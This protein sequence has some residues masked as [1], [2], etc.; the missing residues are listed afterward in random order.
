MNDRFKFRYFDKSEKFMYNVILFDVKGN[1][2]QVDYFHDKEIP[3][4]EVK[5]SDGILMQ[6]T[7]LKDKNVTLIYEGDILKCKENIIWVIQYGHRDENYF[8]QCA[9][10]S[11]EDIADGVEDFAYPFIS[12]KDADEYEFDII[13]NI[14]QNTELLK[15][16]L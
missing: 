6:S 15:I 12:Q 1:Y 4:E 5:L 14:Y 13:G 11:K 16:N 10:L 9:V 3:L 8:W 7:G 2:A